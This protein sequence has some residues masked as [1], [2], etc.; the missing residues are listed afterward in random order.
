MTLANEKPTQNRRSANELYRKLLISHF[1]VAGICLLVLLAAFALTITCQRAAIKFAEVES[2]TAN[3]SAQ[4]LAGVQHSLAALRGWV[5]V[6]SPDFKEERLRAW[7][8][9]IDPAIAELERLSTTW[10]QGENH[11]RLA[12]SKSMLRRLRKAQWWIEDIAGTPGNETARVAFSNNVEPVVEEIQSLLAS[13]IELER[14]R[15]SVP[16]SPP[17]QVEGTNRVSDTISAGSDETLALQLATLQLFIAQSRLTLLRIV[18]DGERVDV[19][20]FAVELDNALA[21]RDTIAL[22]DLTAEQSQLFQEVER[23]VVAYQSLSREVI[24]TR[25]SLDA[26]VAVHLLRT[27]AIPAA[28]A[29]IQQL[30]Q[31]AAVNSEQML[32][33]A[34]AIRRMSNLSILL[35]L[36][37]IGLMLIATVVVSLRSAH[38]FVRPINTLLG[39]VEQLA[40]GKFLEEDL[41][42]SSD[43]QL[44]QLTRAFNRM[45]SELSRRTQLLASSTA[46]QSIA[47]KR[48]QAT[49]DF[50]PVAMLMV[51]QNGKIVL[52]N[53]EM[54]GMFGYEREELLGNTV[55]MLV[56]TH[57]RAEHPQL[58]DEYFKT[59]KPRKMG[60][61]RVLFG[62]RKDGKEIRIE[63]GLNPVET[64]EGTFVLCTLSD[65]TD[66]EN[67]RKATIESEKRFRSL[68]NSSP[69]AMWVNDENASCIWLNDRWAEYTGTMLEENLGSGW[70]NVVHPDD[71]ATAHKTYLAAHEKR[72]T[73]SLSYRLRRHDGEYRWHTAVGRPRF[74]D[75]GRF[76]GY[77]G[78][79]VDDH[80]ARLS[81]EELE[82]SE[83][84]HRAL[85]DQSSNFI[86]LMDLNGNL[87][88]A[89]RTSLKAV[90]V[91]EEEVL[92]QPFWTAPWWVHSEELQAKVRDAVGIAR[93][94]ASVRFEAT[95]YTHEGK[96][97]VVDFSLDPVKDS[98]GKTIFLI[99]EGRDI[100]LHRVREQELQNLL[101]ELDRSNQELEQFAYVASHDLQEPLR[102]ISSYC[103]LLLEEQGSK[104]D[105]EGRDYLNVAI[106]GAGRLSTLVRDLLTF[107]RIKTRGNPLIPTDTQ[108][109]IQ[110]ALDNLELNIRD[111]K[112]SIH[113]GDLQRVVADSSQLTLL[114]Q[115]LIGNAIKYRG[116]KTPEINVSGKT[117]GDFA[118]FCI[119]DNG[120]GVDPQFNER[121]FEIF[122]RLH[123][124]RE[125]SGT[126]IGLA[127][128]K[129]IV[130][131][132]GG[133]IWVEST[134]GKG[135][136]FNFTMKLAEIEKQIDEHD[137]EPEYIGAAN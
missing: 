10:P 100:T 65:V 33:D 19:E 58:R 97:I 55:E 120:L 99:P 49:F 75:E 16:Y 26:N 11:A 53:E 62:R 39:G 136:A 95:H 8:E 91:D 127:L 117:V 93:E 111:S 135:S 116:D 88:E 76:L 9:E 71:Q 43:D 14:Q 1:A 109:C 60:E 94:G 69:F 122:Q 68:A 45:R 115:N 29:A 36:V 105:Q 89:N 131:R 85:I 129:R 34:D 80:E 57:L 132:S 20:N 130:E 47:E 114:F 4:A 108:K 125:Y 44:G 112:A 134:P 24:A 7:E 104:L 13:M 30:S 81:R 54:E 83:A 64:E 78:M 56:P 17:M 119:T 25:Q 133:K 15:F 42:V 40:Q 113:C 21:V 2:P 46:S 84:I 27:E 87:L 70:T 126:G 67:A 77:V 48:F 106:R 98:A 51:N 5:A 35:W 92:N 32:K 110:A 61:G 86:G 66:V 90:G 102:K 79:S 50:A 73:F 137:H 128:C 38:A 107:S 22:G 12:K 103:E 118:Q 63:T 59:P 123:N 37:F 23:A 3:T 96:K 41:P 121:I 31:L 74:D 124:R 6:E 28:D 18:D 52:A 82:K 72:E 101:D